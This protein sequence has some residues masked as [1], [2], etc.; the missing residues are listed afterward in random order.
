ML[1]P[2]MTWK[3]NWVVN[4]ALY[5]LNTWAFSYG[6]S[7][8]PPRLGTK[9]KKDFV[10]IEPCGRGNTF[11]KMAHRLILT[12]SILSNLPT[13]VLSLFCIPKG[14]NLRLER[15]KRGF[16]WGGGNLVKKIHLVNWS[17][18][19]LR[20]ENGSLRIRNLFNFNRALLG[21]WNWLF[22]GE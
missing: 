10:S 4:W 21:K 14:I 22:A 1:C 15:I 5:R 13:Y 11:R 17:M 12:R 20:K 3:L 6:Q 8:I 2:G 18:I 9:L 7:L 16:L 19:C